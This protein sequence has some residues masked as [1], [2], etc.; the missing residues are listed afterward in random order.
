MK[1]IFFLL[2]IIL[3]FSCQDC[4][5]AELNDCGARGTDTEKCGW[6]VSTCYGGFVEGKVLVNDPRA[7]VGVIY[8]TSFA[9]DAPRGTDWGLTIEEIHPINWT[10]GRIGQVFG[11]AIDK[12]ENIYLASSDIYYYDHYWPNRDVESGNLN[13][14]FGCG[15]IFKCQPPLY[16]PQP[17]CDLP[18]NCELL[19]GTGNI[20][21]DS[22]NNQFFATNMEDGKI[23]RIDSVGTIVETYDPWQ[24]DDGA[25]GICPQ[26]ERI[27]GIAATSEEGQVRLYFPRVDGMGERSI[28]SLELNGD[29]FPE[30]GSEELEI[31]NVPGTQ[32]IISD[33][34]ISMDG[35]KLILTERGNPHT[36][37]THLY[38]KNN[39]NWTYSHKYFVGNAHNET[40]GNNSGGGVDFGYNKTKFNSTGSN[41]DDIVFN[42]VN[43]AF[44]RADLPNSTRDVIYGVQGM[45]VGGN[46]PSN[47]PV[48]EANKDTDLFIDYNGEYETRDKEVPGDVE[49]FDCNSCTPPCKLKNRLK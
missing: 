49:V 34:A 26:P 5:P 29:S 43:Y 39:E 38:E 35:Q 24:S 22:W 47:L 23:Y 40:G 14:P 7:A 10:V 28:Y 32:E 1:N 16:N 4:E 27:W 15:Q 48:P 44:P 42:T 36:A 12:H 25:K 18:S 6:S 3:G 9:G 30:A 31:L 37:S 19:N 41:C 2:I 17:F 20:A 45:D 8:N 46:N 21:Y 13:R 33:I 11:V